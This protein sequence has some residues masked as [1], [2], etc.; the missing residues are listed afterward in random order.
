MLAGTAAGYLSAWTVLLLLCIYSALN[1]IA[2]KPALAAAAVRF[3]VSLSL[4]QLDMPLCR[5][6]RW[7]THF[8]WHGVNAAT[9]GLTTWARVQ[10]GRVHRK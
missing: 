9:L 1:K 10:A 8:A 2:S 7:G 4:R 5:D 6:W 3:A